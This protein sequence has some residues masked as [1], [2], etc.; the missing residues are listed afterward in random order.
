MSIFEKI[1]SDLNNL[2][3]NTEVMLY[4]TQKKQVGIHYLHAQC[5]KLFVFRVAGIN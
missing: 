2:D 1:I 5:K 3:N 4:F